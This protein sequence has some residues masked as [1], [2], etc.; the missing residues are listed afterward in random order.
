MI[1]FYSLFSALLIYLAVVGI[2]GVLKPVFD[3]S[4][5]IFLGKI[6]Y[7][8]YLYHLFVPDLVANGLIYFGL[9]GLH[10]F[11]IRCI[12]V[13]LTLGICTASWYGIEKPMARLKE[14]FGH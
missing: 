8:L 12:F 14:R 13:V 1:P 5:V 6:S 11:W 10:V 9:T 4:F 7:G 3:N 2:R